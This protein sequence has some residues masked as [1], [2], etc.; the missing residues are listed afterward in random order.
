MKKDFIKPSASTTTIIGSS[1]GPTSVFV[2]SGKYKL[3]LKQQ[4]QKKS[5]ELRKKWY[6]L[7]IKPNPHTI[8]EV[9]DYIRKKYDFIEV[10]RTSKKYQRLYQEL[11]SSFI[12]QY[13]PKLLG[14]YAALP[15][16]KSQSQ[17]DVKEFLE[18]M[19][20][21]QEK[22]NEVPEELF[23]L[24]CYF[25]EMQEKDIHM[26]IQLESHFEYIGGGTSGRK[27]S[28]FHKIY[29]DV[30]KYYGVSEDDIKNHTK[31]YEN[32]LRQLAIRH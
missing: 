5:F 3:S 32:L 24:D 30:Y 25:F 21:R 29:K 28:K 1:D 8:E 31:R 26:E 17:E 19:H 20:M 4:L 22:A 27:V 10:S 14:E 7:W 9:V 16:L 15:E 12:M 18:K 13:E 23:S 2:A 6:A 11:R